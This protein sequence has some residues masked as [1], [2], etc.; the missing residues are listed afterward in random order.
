MPTPQCAGC[1]EALR[2]PVRGEW[3]PRCGRR[4]ANC[5]LETCA[6]CSG[7]GW[8]GLYDYG[9]RVAQCAVLYRALDGLVRQLRGRQSPARELMKRVP[10]ANRSTAQGEFLAFELFILLRVGRSLEGV[11]LSDRQMD[12]L[13]DMAAAM[14]KRYLKCDPAEFAARCR[15][16]WDEYSPLLGRVALE[17]FGPAPLAYELCKRVGIQPVLTDTSHMTGWYLARAH[18]AAVLWRIVFSRGSADDPCAVCGGV[19]HFA[20]ERPSG[21]CAYCGGTGRNPGAVAGEPGTR[22]CPR[23]GG[24]GWEAA[25][26]Q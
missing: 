22:R 25:S 7:S 4:L 2:S 9:F 26:H 6:W 16:R 15:Q 1:I 3:C 11:T 21:S 12:G 20:L 13:L 17:L 8:G 18:M 23:C 10:R 24:S 14:A 19:G 5:V